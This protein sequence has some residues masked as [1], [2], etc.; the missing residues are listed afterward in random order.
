MTQPKAAV[1]CSM[2]QIIT[3]R[4]S[5]GTPDVTMGSNVIV[6]THITIRHSQ[7]ET[8]AFPHVIEGNVKGWIT[9]AVKGW[10]RD[11]DGTVNHRDHAVEAWRHLTNEVSPSWVTELVADNLPVWWTA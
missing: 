9:I 7:H 1:P 2:E 10:L 6:P 5:S 11:Q 3:Y 8:F 4:L